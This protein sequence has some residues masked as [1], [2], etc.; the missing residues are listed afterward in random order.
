V[1]TFSTIGLS[2]Q[3]YRADGT[4][5][6]HCDRRDGWWPLRARP[7]RVSGFT[8]FLVR[9]LITVPYLLVWWGLFGNSG[10]SNVV[11]AVVLAFIWATYAQFHSP[12]GLPDTPLRILNPAPP[13]ATV[14]WLDYKEL[15]LISLPIYLVVMLGV[16]VVLSRRREIGEN[17]RTVAAAAMIPVVLFTA[18]FTIDPDDRGVSAS[19]GASGDVEIEDQGAGTGVISISATDMGSRCRRTISCR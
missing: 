1:G 17:R 2:I 16:M 12:G 15:W 3:P 7:R 10:I 19:F 9:L 4:R 6:W 11:G 18:A 14:R 13:P 8:W 5:R